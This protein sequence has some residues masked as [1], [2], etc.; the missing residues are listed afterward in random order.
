VYAKKF[1]KI[2]V[3]AD[4][5][6]YLTVSIWLISSHLISLITCSKHEFI[7]AAFLLLIN[8]HEKISC[9]KL[10][11]MDWPLTNV[12]VE[13]QKTAIKKCGLLT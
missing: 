3:E 7:S 1:Y 10:D 8:S 9:V 4:A 5:E 13:P 11:G 12:V 6:S 2:T